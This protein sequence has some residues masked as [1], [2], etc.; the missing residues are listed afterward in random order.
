MSCAYPID[1]II[2]YVAKAKTKYPSIGVILRILP[3]KIASAPVFKCLFLLRRN[4]Y[5]YH[6]VGI[7]FPCRI[8]TSATLLKNRQNHFESAMRYLITRTD[9]IGDVVL[10]FPLASL[11]KQHFGKEAEILYLTRN[12]TEAA[13]AACPDVDTF[14]SNDYLQSLSEDEAVAYLK[15]LNIDVF[16]PLYQDEYLS[17]LAYKAK[18]PLRLGH[19]HRFYFLR[20]ANK[21]LWR[22]KRKKC[23]LHQAQMGLQYLKVF[24]LPW[25]YTRDEIIP[26]IHLHPKHFAEVDQLITPGVFHLVIHPGNNGHTI[27][28]SKASF[29]KLVSLIPPEVKVYISGSAKEKEL[30]GD[31]LTLHPNTVDLFGKLPLDQYI[32][33]LSKVD[34]LVVGSTGPLHL[35]AALKT[36]VI[37]LF[38]P[39]Q[40]LDVKRWGALSHQAINLEAAPCE[41]FKQ[42]ERCADLHMIQPEE[43]LALMKSRWHQ[44]KP[45]ADIS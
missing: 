3:S 40:D 1:N 44:L 24:H 12:Y 45:K 9:N 22:F 43:V 7:N 6:K 21:L 35:A 36:P 32:Y 10:S 17:R 27:G 26:L 29:A 8:D 30:Y 19:L 20:Y 2:N 38:P 28:W 16:I 42:G 41:H 18:I 31:L 25:Q 34:G 33:F 11:L 13:V 15:S 39:H 37:G 4:Y 14:I 23:E 5:P